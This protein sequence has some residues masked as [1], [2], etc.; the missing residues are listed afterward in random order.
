MDDWQDLVE[1][2]KNPKDEITIHFVGKYVEYEDSYKSINEALY[3]GGFQHRLKVNAQVRRGR[4][5]RAAGRRAAARRRRRHPGGPGLRRSRQPRHDGGGRVRARTQ[6]PYFGICYGFQW[7]VV[8][9]ARNVCRPGRAPTRPKSPRHAAQDHL[10]AARPARRRRHGRHDAARQLRLP[11]R[12][13]TRS[14][15]KLYGEEDHPR[16]ASP[17]LRVQLPVREDARPTTA[18]G[19]SAARSTASS[20]RSSSCRAPVVRGRAVPSRVQVE[21]AA[22]ASAVCRLRRGAPTSGKH[23]AR[24]AWP[25]NVTAIGERRAG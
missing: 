17:S 18:C 16:A 14:R 11:A 15:F 21:A 5:A 10:Q 19:S 20:S 8:E 1:R 7:A 4:G 22:P 3:H 24:R 9:F 13:R 6:I 25:T 12:A 2:I 23:G